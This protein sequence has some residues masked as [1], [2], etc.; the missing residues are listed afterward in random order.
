MAE[1]RNNPPPSRFEELYKEHPF[2]VGCA[3]TAAGIA[4]W[5]GTV[6][7]IIALAMLA[8]LIAGISIDHRNE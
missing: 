7:W 6:W 3:T 4:A 8:G 1:A 5:F 2:G